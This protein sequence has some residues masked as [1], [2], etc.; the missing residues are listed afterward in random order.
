ML[1]LKRVLLWQFS[2]YVWTFENAAALVMLLDGLVLLSNPQRTGTVIYFNLFLFGTDTIFFLAV[3][4]VV[5]ALAMAFRNLPPV[6]LVVA[7]LPM[8]FYAFVLV[9]MTA[10][11]PAF[12]WVRA[13]EWATPV[14]F[15][16]F[17]VLG[18]LYAHPR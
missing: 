18:K 16:L 17:R 5:H 14:I 7:Y 2:P 3:W 1:T 4:M 9:Y 6:A 8:I 11:Y 12:S 13:L 10:V 15:V